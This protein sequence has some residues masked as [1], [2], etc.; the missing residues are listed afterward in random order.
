MQWMY[1]NC[2]WAKS[3]HNI[4]KKTETF[5]DG[6]GLHYAGTEGLAT[7]IFFKNKQF[8]FAFLLE[9]KEKEKE[10]RKKKAGEINKEEKK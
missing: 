2:Y 7:Q 3:V 1:H 10:K 8:F 9:S 6:S 4:K 5:Q